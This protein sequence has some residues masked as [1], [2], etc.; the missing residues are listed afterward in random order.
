MKPNDKTCLVTRS[1]CYLMLG[2]STKALAD[3]ESALENDEDGKG[4]DIRV[5]SGFYAYFLFIDNLGLIDI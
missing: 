1:K 4:K 3:S 5:S 2:N